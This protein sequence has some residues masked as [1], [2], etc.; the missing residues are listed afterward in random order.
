ME[1]YPFIESSP[2]GPRQPLAVAATKTQRALGHVGVN[3]WV[4]LP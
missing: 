2:C 1:A 4:V 3:Q